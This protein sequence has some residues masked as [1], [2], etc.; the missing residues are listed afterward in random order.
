MLILPISSPNKCQFF[1]K[2]QIFFEIFHFFRIKYPEVFIKSVFAKNEAVVNARDGAGRTPL[3]YAQDEGHTKI[4][5]LLLKRG[6]A[7]K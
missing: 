7:L 6:K 3:W 5:E 2:I 4:A 1:A